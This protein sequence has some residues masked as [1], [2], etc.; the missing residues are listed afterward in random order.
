MITTLAEG[1][2]GGT[3]EER[4]DEAEQRHHRDRDRDD[5]QPGRAHGGQGGGRQTGLRR[6]APGH[7]AELP[8]HRGDRQD[9]QAGDHVHLEHGAAKSG[10]RYRGPRPGQ[11]CALP[12]Q[13][14]VALFGIVTRQLAFLSVLT[15]LRTHR[16]ADTSRTTAEMSAIPA[17]AAARIHGMNDCGSGSPRRSREWLRTH[18]A[19][20]TTASTA[21]SAIS[22]T[23]R[24]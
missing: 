17:I 13:A 5:E 14:R 16:R 4:D 22:G 12:A 9:D 3:A 23:P 20:A 18:S 1:S 2:G 19:S 6:A 15:V 7:P 8:D 21:P 24:R 10:E 11:R